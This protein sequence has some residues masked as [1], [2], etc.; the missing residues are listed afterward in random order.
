[1]TVLHG[2]FD[3]ASFM[4]LVEGGYQDPIGLSGDGL[5]P[6]HGITLPVEPIDRESRLADFRVVV[7]RDYR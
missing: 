6:L 3:L 5:L 1:M 7:T 2:G 4:P